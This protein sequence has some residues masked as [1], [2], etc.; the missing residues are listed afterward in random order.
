M[1]NYA[2]FRSVFLP[3]LGGT[4]LCMNRPVLCIQRAVSVELHRIGVS[5]IDDGPTSNWVPPL[6]GVVDIVGNP[7][8]SHAQYIWCTV[9]S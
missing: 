4:V 1:L 7:G 8:L 5:V 3:Q 9:D 6:P 2:N